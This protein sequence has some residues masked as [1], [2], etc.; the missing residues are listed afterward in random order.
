MEAAVVRRDFETIVNDALTGRFQVTVVVLCA[1]LVLIDGFD[2]QALALVAPEIGREWHVSVS[3][4][5]TVFGMGLLG[6]AVGAMLFG[7]ISDRIGRKVPLLVAVGLFGVVSLLTPLAGSLGDLTAFR[8]TTGLGLGGAVPL[9]ISTTSEFAPARARATLVSTMFCGYPLGV[10]IAGL[11]TTPLLGSIGWAGIFYLGGVVPLLF[12]VVLAGLFPESIRFLVAK[13][14]R[15]PLDRVLRRMRIPEL[16]D[17]EIALRSAPHRSRIKSLFTEGRAQGTVLLWITLFFTLMLAYFLNSWIVVVTRAAGIPAQSAILGV[18]ALNLGGIVGSVVLGRLAD[19]RNPGFVVGI[20]YL[21]GAVFIVL[22]GQVSHSSALLLGTAFLAGFF[23]LGA[24]LCTMPVVANFYAVR[25]RGTGVG[26]STG[27]GRVG[28]ILGPTL[29][30]A[31][32][33]AGFGA[34]AIF[35]F[36]AALSVAAGVPM[37][38]IGRFV[39]QKS[40]PATVGSATTLVVEAG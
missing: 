17:G 10:V 23:T 15:A 32:V 28:A 11:V 5:G 31:L 16:L 7:M 30:G 35:V 18:V 1:I 39:L 3:A 37:L 21:I 38:L 12:L 34:P 36:A 9:V 13:K 33:A 22:I 20:G 19:R 6:A 25:E 27:I 40:H 8:F 24:Q 4:F 26:W 2:T 14:N 29:G